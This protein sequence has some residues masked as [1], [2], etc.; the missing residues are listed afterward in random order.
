M[1][2]IS[3]ALPSTDSFTDGRTDKQ[4]S[5]QAVGAKKNPSRSAATSNPPLK[6]AVDSDEAIFRAVS[7]D[8][9]AIA[10]VFEYADL[11]INQGLTSND[12]RTAGVR[13]IK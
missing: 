10:A 13:F 2:I 6:D 12:A 9:V 3:R 5:R 11:V 4:T 7:C 1:T 8:V